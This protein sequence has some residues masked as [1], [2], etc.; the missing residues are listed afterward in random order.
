MTGPPGNSLL[1]GRPMTAGSINSNSVPSSPSL[2]SSASKP[3]VGQ[4]YLSK[5]PPRSASAVRGR[6]PSAPSSFPA[7]AAVILRPSSSRAFDR[8]GG[9]GA[10][11]GSPRSAAPLS[12]SYA[13]S[14]SDGTSGGLGRG[15]AGLGIHRSRQAAEAA[16][17]ALTAA[18]RNC[19]RRGNAGDES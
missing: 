2:H 16:S 1:Q 8:I 5:A 18:A 10:A 3:A 6:N 12:P 11:V 9:G 19:I 7:A 15:G 17:A 13:Y 4:P 14:S